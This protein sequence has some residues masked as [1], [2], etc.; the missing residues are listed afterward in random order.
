MPNLIIENGALNIRVGHENSQQPN[1]Y[2]LNK[3]INMP[4]RNYLDFSTRHICGEDADLLEGVYNVQYPIIHGKI[5]DWKSMEL[6]WKELMVR[7][8]VVSVE[9]NSSSHSSNDIYFLASVNY[10]S[11]C[12]N[13]IL[14]FFFQNYAVNKIG[15][16]LDAINALHS[17]G[18]KS[19]IVVDS[20][21]SLTKIVPILD[22][23]V[24]PKMIWQSNIAGD[25]F[26]SKIRRHLRTTLNE[27]VHS[28]N[29]IDYLKENFFVHKT[30][31]LQMSNSIEKVSLPD[32]TK[33]LLGNERYYFA[34]SVFKDA[35]LDGEKLIEGFFKTFNGLDR[36][37]KQ[38][39][40][41]KTLLIGGNTKTKNFEKKFLEEAQ[42]FWTK[43]EIK[44]LVAGDPM[45]TSF[46]GSST[47]VFNLNETSQSISRSEHEEFGHGIVFRKKIPLLF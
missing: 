40:A 19:G 1:L 15:F 7:I 41:E 27:P 39:L 13:R 11:H 23:Y 25:T 37:S 3:V 36:K 6:I 30:N 42:E 46:K 47:N 22:G 29:A 12:Y 35:N 31:D 20:G 10:T 8:G 43:I 45:I 33:V 28:K 38:H 32:G 4:N 34:D 2:F 44:T 9:E 18:H 17:T 16:G 26:S 14:D 5:E 21:H 24:D